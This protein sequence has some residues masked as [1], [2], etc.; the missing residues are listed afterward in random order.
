MTRA[1][2][3]VWAL[4]LLAAAF[5]FAVLGV[6]LA[7]EARRYYWRWRLRRAWKQHRR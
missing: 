7:R 2:L 1:D 3:A 6:Q 5:V 4:C